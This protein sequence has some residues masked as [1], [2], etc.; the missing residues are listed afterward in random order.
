M[1]FVP[2]GK[3]KSWSCL[4]CGNCCKRGFTV[5]LR[6]Y[7]YVRI[8]EFAS[9]A[10]ESDSYGRMYLRKNGS[11]CIFLN[12]YG[13]C[14]LQQLNLKPLPC[15]VWPL[16]IS[17]EPKSFSTREARFCYG[18]EEYYVYLNPYADS[19]C[20]GI[21]RGNPERLTNIISE[22]IDLCRDPSRKQNYSTSAFVHPITTGD[23]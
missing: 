22:A 23:Y 2:W 9:E 13:L 4:G 5:Y 17:S 12:E 21:G 16:I 10:V 3:V 7:E 18:S 19:V 14:G 8:L 1:G 6:T 11:R 20:P 15:K